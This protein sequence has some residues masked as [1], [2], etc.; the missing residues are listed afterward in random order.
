LKRDRLRI[1]LPV[2]NE[3]L[4][5]VFVPILSILLAFLV[6]A[7]FILLAKVNP[8]TVYYEIF[9]GA[10]ATRIGLTESMIKSLP[11]VLAGLGMSF[12]FRCG[13]Y[14]IG[15]EGQI[16]LGAL[17]AT[18]VAVK[19]NLPIF[20]HLPL[21]IMAG[22]MS[23]GIWALIAG[24]LKTHYKVNELI[25]TIML[26][27]IGIYLVGIFVYG[28]LREPGSIFPQSSQFPPS[29]IFS[30]LVPG[31]RLHGGVLLAIIAT[32]FVYVFLWKTVSGFNIR[33]V[34]VNPE[35]ARFSGISVEK[36][37]LIAMFISGGLAGLAGVGEVS[38]LT[39]RLFDNFSSGYGYQAVAVALLGQTHPVGVVLAGIF[40]GA[41]RNGTTIMQRALGVPTSLVFIIQGLVILFVVGSSFY[42]T[43]LIK[44]QAGGG[45]KDERLGDKL[46]G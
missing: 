38:G 46:S 3:K 24:W 14:N 4:L 32:I 9:K 10:F 33:A 36:N 20:L 16:F 28:P 29:A 13:V 40:F 6:G 15:G 30:V 39:Q 43:Q 22:F 25:T 2:R 21:V 18:F 27:Y 1:F 41:L 7:F 12:A 26:N 35:A 31:T 8:L 11:L 45:M 19:L 44:K 42:T 34:G 23:G 37:I 17:G 5:I